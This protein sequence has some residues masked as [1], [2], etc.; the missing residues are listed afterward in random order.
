MG[1]LTSN[2]KRIDECFNVH[3]PFSV[4]SPNYICSYSNSIDIHI[5]KKPRIG[6]PGKVIDLQ[7]SSFSRFSSYPK[8]EKLPRKV[9]AP[10]R[11]NKFRSLSSGLRFDD[12]GMGNS[13]KAAYEQA[14]HSA[15]NGLRFVIVGKDKNGVV[16]KNCRE[17]EIAADNGS[18]ELEL[19]IQ[20]LDGKGLEI[21]AIPTSSTVSDFTDVENL[22][23]GLS[24]LL[25]EREKYK[26]SGSNVVRS[27]P[28]LSSLEF[29]IKLQEARFQCMQS[30]EKPKE[31][32]LEDL[33]FEPFVPL[34]EE[35]EREV[36]RAFSHS[37]RSKILVNHE[38]SNIDITG[39]ILQC[40]RPGEWLNDEVINV[41]LELLKERERREPKK[42]LNCH[43]FNTFFYKKLVGGRNGYDYKA[44]RR[45][46]TQRKLGYG[47][48]D[49]DKIFVPI[50]KEVH[51]CLAVINKK[52]KSFQYLDS[53]GGRDLQVLVA[54]SKYYVDEVKDKG[55]QHIDVCEWKLECVDDLPEQHNAKNF[56]ARRKTNLHLSEK[57]GKAC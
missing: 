9:H 23:K 42:F 15:I 30:L 13:L 37:N 27:Y 54:L 1:D 34:T 40:L 29:E 52:D 2:P 22:C 26:K 33:L 3:T 32:R 21:G 16:S 49:C 18:D 38:N 51:W 46:T 41:Y 17:S 19:K 45:W 36:L 7:K 39:E 11:S 44:V 4:Y 10:C 35:E 57:E 6:K 55:G 28:K 24:S 12:S 31:K 56:R 47:L 43:F 20:G 14:K 50:H 48:V 25:V 8:P 5:A 53:L